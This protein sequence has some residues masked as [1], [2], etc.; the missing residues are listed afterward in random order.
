MISYH[1]PKFKWQVFI[2]MWYVEEEHK[3]R[4]EDG[5]DANEE[6]DPQPGEVGE[7]EQPHFGSAGTQDCGQAGYRG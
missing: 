7:Q 5:E 1:S 2:K 6:E 4:E 3:G